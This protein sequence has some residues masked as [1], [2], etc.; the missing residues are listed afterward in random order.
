MSGIFR[1]YLQTVNRA[2]QMFGF[3]RP[4][5]KKKVI[6]DVEKLLGNTVAKDFFRVFK[7]PVN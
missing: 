2:D 5:I 3:Q 6:I 4:D 1:K 7:A